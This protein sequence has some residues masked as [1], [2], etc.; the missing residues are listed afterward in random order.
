M[1][2][3]WAVVAL[4]G[5]ASVAIRAIGPVALGGRQ[6]P[7]RF[8]GFVELLAPAVLAALVVTQVAGGNRE[9][10]LDERLAGLAAAAVALRLRAPTLAVIFAA[11]AVTALTRAL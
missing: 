5:V 8:A 6:L 1:S 9:L 10:I 4:V 3:V 2:G 11:A 7:A